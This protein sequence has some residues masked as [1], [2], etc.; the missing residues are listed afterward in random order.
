M[1]TSNTKKLVFSAM[2]IAL[3]ITVATVLTLPSLP[4]GGS[5]TLFSMLIVTLIGYWYGPKMGITAGV[6]YGILQ[7][8]TGPYFLSPIQVSLDYLLAFGA[9][10]FSGFFSNHRNGLVLGYLAGVFGRY[11]F[12]MASGLI[13][14]TEYVGDLNGNIFAIYGAFAYNFSYIGTEC[15]ITLLLLSVPSVRTM[16][17]QV[18]TLATN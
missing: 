10:G 4:S 8:I 13:F 9:L 11:F 15:I 7:F 6:A 16:L 2:A 17:K 1:Q 18:K 12:T 3:A 5:T 14:Y